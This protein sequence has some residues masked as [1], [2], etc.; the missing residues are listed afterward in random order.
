MQFRASSWNVNNRNFRDT[1]AELLRTVDTDVL[2]LQEVSP[3]FYKELANTGLFDWSE[4]SLSLRPPQHEEGRSR[5]L[6]C[7]V[8]G[9]SPFQLTTAELLWELQFPERALIVKINSGVEL[10]MCSFHT[11]PGASWGEI[12]P[13]TLR[14]IAEW[15]TKQSGYT[16]FGIDANAPK[17]DHPVFEQNEWWWKD[18]PTLLGH[19]PL[20]ELRD[21]LRLYLEERPQVLEEIVSRR[22]TGPLAISHIRGNGRKMTECRYDFIYVSPGLDVLDVNYL[23]EESV[24]AGSDHALVTALLRIRGESQGTA[25]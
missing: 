7:A 17:T 1:H 23:Y 22:P 14:A 24:Q 4:F 11:P 10:R 15:L 6:G 25:V 16:I 5:R 9:R 13:Q 19:S 18:E 12:K 8:F 20:H 21:C 2:A 3:G